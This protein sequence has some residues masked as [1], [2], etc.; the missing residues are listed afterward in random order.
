MTPPAIDTGI[1]RARL[2]DAPSIADI[3][4]RSWQTV[5]RGMMTDD[6]LASQLP[7]QRYARWER[8]ISASDD[9]MA[10]FVAEEGETDRGQH[11]RR[12]LGFC[13][14]CPQRD[15]APGDDLLAPAGELHTMYVD[16]MFKGAG[17]VR[18]LIE[19]GEDQLRDMGFQRAIVWM[20][21]DNLAARGFYEPMGWQVDGT[22]ALVR[23]GDGEVLE[24]RLAKQLLA[25]SSGKV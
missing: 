20:L 22:T 18:R 1:R 21:A 24:I 2:T 3:H 11:R 12:L 25:R 14:V 6:F 7:S 10:V 8:D 5:Y 16:V 15:P 23:Y 19:R 4:V 9:A 13:S 17:I